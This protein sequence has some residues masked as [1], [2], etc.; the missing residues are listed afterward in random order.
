LALAVVAPTAALLY[1]IGVEEAALRAAFGEEYLAYTRE[2][3]RLI[4]G[5]F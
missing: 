4:P 1:R 2:T 3:K 5:L